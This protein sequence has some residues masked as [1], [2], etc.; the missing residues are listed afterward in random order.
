L[1]CR[2]QQKIAC[3]KNAKMAFRCKPLSQSFT[4]KSKEFQIEKSRG[5]CDALNGAF[6]IE[7]NHKNTPNM[8][9]F[10]AF[11]QQKCENMLGDA[12]CLGSE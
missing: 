4:N 8:Q 1:L 7:K 6:W 10:Q 2:L 9:H 5:C 11:F 3:N 12:A